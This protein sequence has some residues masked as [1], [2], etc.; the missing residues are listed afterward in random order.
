MNDFENELFTLCA[1]DVRKSHPGV[2]IIG[3]YVRKPSAFPAVTLCETQNVMVDELMDSSHEERYSGLTYRLQVFSN[4]QKGKKAEAKAIFATADKA[5]RSV[6][7]RRK[8]YTTTPDIYDATIF[9]ITATYEGIV[10]VN[11]TIYQR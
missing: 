10:D 4:K 1:T 11:G 2:T 8:T 3:E 9:S 5:L 7:L 6:G